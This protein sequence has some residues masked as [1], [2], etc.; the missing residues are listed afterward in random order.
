MPFVTGPSG[1]RNAP[2]T[3]VLVT[4]VGAG[5]TVA[6]L[7]EQPAVHTHHS[8]WRL[9][10]SQWVFPGLGTT[11]VGTWLIY[12]LRVIERRYGSAKFASL[13]FISIVMSTL[14]HKVLDYSSAPL[15]TGPYALIFALL[16]QFH[17]LVP[18]TSHTKFWCFTLS[19]KSDAYAVALQL[20]VCQ[21]PAALIPATF[22]WVTG[23]VYDANLGNIKRWRFP[24]ALQSFASSYILPLLGTRGPLAPLHSARDH[25]SPSTRS[26]PRSRQAHA[27]AEEV[28]VPPSAENVD[29]L[30]A[31]FPDNSQ[32]SINNAL[33]RA[34]N[35]LSR[36]AD[37]LLAPE[38]TF[39]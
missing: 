1:F 36:A 14:F 39:S 32:E 31:M 15:A 34:N 26:T 27:A 7:V 35:D 22:G 30:S 13:V 18:A 8:F 28:Q 16:C 24:R 3:K 17:H 38:S 5:S 10:S 21:L 19:D 23:L 12:R 29:A 25:P 2:V 4:I 6:N 20:L 37:F 9:A 11:L 33:V